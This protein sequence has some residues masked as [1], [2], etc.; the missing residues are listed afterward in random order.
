MF[1]P[2]DVTEK[3]LYIFVK[4]FVTLDLKMS[5]LDAVRA[6]KRKMFHLSTIL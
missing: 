4:K 6:S 3:S 5:T 1:E 2:V